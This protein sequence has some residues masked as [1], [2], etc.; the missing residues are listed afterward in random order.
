[1]EKNPNKK[2]IFEAGAQGLTPEDV[3][4]LAGQQFPGACYTP[5]GIDIDREK[6]RLNP[7]FCDPWEFLENLYT[8]QLNDFYSVA[9]E[10]RPQ[11]L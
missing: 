2:I 5:G 9:I 1:M 8:E 11:T 6:E 7:L 10:Q 4:I 3:L